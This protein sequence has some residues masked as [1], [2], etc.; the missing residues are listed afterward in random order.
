MLRQTT[1]HTQ[2][3]LFVCSLS[4]FQ[5]HFDKALWNAARLSPFSLTVDNLRTFW[6]NSFTRREHMFTFL[7]LLFYTLVKLFICEWEIWSS[8]ANLGYFFLALSYNVQGI[9]E[10]TILI[11]TKE[12]V[13]KSV[14]D[15]LYEI[16][17]RGENGPV[18][19]LLLSPWQQ[20]TMWPAW[21]LS[22]G[23]ADLIPTPLAYTDSSNI[24]L[25][26]KN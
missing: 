6:D 5:L 21:S 17:V 1:N 20:V 22:C 12:R 23:V 26:V 10:T 7:C 9:I 15:W 19:G 14:N 2:T 24:V 4:S 16:G 11:W 25:N 3:M 13:K 18:F 8:P